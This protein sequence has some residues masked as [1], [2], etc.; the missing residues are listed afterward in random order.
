ML[1]CRSFFA[2]AKLNYLI[3]EFGGILDDKGLLS[4]IG[5]I[6]F[7]EPHLIDFLS[8]DLDQLIYESTNINTT[9]T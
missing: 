9:I 2:I 4:L 8:V 3:L 7:V 1:P 6:G 5:F